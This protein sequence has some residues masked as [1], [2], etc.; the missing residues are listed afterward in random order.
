MRSLILVTI[1]CLASTSALACMYDTQCE[2]GT[3]CLKGACVRA[4]SSGD[5]DDIPRSIEREDLQLRW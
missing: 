4:H 3:V 5:D 1:L 2:Q